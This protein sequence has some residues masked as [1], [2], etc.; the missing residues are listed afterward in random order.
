MGKSRKPHKIDWI[1]HFILLHSNQPMM[2]YSRK[3]LEYFKGIHTYQTRVN[4]YPIV[5]IVL[6]HLNVNHVCLTP[7]INPI[8][9]SLSEFRFNQRNCNISE[10]A[11]VQSKQNF[12]SQ[13]R[14]VEHNISRFSQLL[15]RLG[16][17]NCFVD[18][19]VERKV[20][21]FSQLDISTSRTTLGLLPGT[22]YVTVACYCDSTI[23]DKAFFV[24]GQVNEEIVNYTQYKIKALM[25][26]VEHT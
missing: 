20:S 23:S 7:T 6:S 5:C 8:N 15:A 12:V 17:S 1:V 16:K 22:K 13:Q 10:I 14:L 18:C 24:R 26:K 19:L 9:E 21:R 11:V 3:S 4:Y 2:Y 25:F